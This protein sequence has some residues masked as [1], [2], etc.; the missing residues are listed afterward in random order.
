MGVGNA[1]NAI[2]WA[3]GV[4]ALADSAAAALLWCAAIASPALILCL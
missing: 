2:K 1:I 3:T 4:L